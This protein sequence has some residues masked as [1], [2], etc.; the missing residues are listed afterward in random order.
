MLDRILKRRNE[1]LILR[2]IIGLMA[3]VLAERS[4]FSSRLILND[5]TIAR[6]PGIAPRPAIAMSDQVVLGCFGM[7]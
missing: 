3:K 6:R 7:R 2:E 5:D 4:N 1:T